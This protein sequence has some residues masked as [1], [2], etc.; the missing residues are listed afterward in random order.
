MILQKPN[1]DFHYRLSVF[2]IY[3]LSYFSAGIIDDFFQRRKDDNLTKSFYM[4]SRKETQN[5]SIEKLYGKL[6][7]FRL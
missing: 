4:R 5:D 7:S 6:S 3:P 2:D 1:T